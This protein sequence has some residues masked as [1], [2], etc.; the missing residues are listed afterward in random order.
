MLGKLLGALGLVSLMLLPAAIAVHGEG[1][2]AYGTAIIKDANGLPQTTYLV[3]VNWGGYEFPYFTVTLKDP[4]TQGIVSKETFPG[5]WEANGPVFLG[6]EL[7]TYHGYAVIGSPG[8]GGFGGTPDSAH[9]DING[10]QY[11]QVTGGAPN[12]AVMYYSGN[13]WNYDLTLVVPYLVPVPF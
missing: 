5:G 11:Q 6:T 7:L 9:F 8:W 2:D 4:T 13:Y 10:F 1:Y 12:K 3:H